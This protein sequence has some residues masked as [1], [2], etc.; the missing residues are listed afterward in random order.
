VYVRHVLFALFLAATTSVASAEDSSFTWRTDWKDA[1]KTAKQQHRL[2]FVDYFASW[3]QPC[4]QMDETVLRDAEVQRRLGD[5]VLLRV[6]VDHGVIAA[7]HRVYSYPTYV[8]YDPDERER[9]RIIG[10]RQL[11]LFSEVIEEV[12]REAPAFIKASDLFDAKQDVEASFLAGNTYSHL[13]MTDYARLSYAGAQK[14]AEKR[15]D[16]G[17]AQL[18][19]ALGAFTY[20]RE[21]DAPRAIRLLQKLAAK[22]ADRNSEAFIWLTL[23]NAYR[24]TKDV[25]AALDAYGRAKSA[26]DPN[27][28]AYEEATAAIASLRNTS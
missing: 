21:G 9:F 14:A 28:A 23:G 26:A 11:D 25:K 4:R 13:G 20:C 6:N 16:K 15:N 27:S 7:T 24:S 18:A 5:F 12:R 3:C 1:F 17:S 2:V 22:P 8:F 10:A 19:E